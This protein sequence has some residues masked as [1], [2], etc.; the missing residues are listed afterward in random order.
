MTL[1]S[2]V[3][4][5]DAHFKYISAVSCVFEM[6][7]TVSRQ[8]IDTGSLDCAGLPN[9][10]LVWKWRQLDNVKN[11]EV[12][13]LQ[14]WYTDT[15]GPLDHTHTVW[16][17]CTPVDLINTLERY[18]SSCSYVFRVYCTL[19]ILYCTTSGMQSGQKPFWVSETKFPYIKKW[20]LHI[21]N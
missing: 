19:Q 1:C 5:V 6:Y 7:R 16:G 13:G 17:P 10:W 12:H 8:C 4:K 3:F 21:W 20:T 11:V 9:D 15:W 2:Y 18:K 14:T